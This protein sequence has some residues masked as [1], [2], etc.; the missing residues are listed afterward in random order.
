MT[1]RRQPRNYV[2]TLEERVASLEN[3]LRNNRSKDSEMS[4]G[5]Q[6]IH[7]TA[8]YQA[9]SWQEKDQ[10]S[11]SELSSSVGM[12]GLKVNGEEPRYLGSSSV[13]AFSRVIHSSLHLPSSRS[14]LEGFGG[15]EQDTS[16]DFSC[17]LPDDALAVRLSNA[18]FENIH[19]QYPFLHEPTFRQWEARLI[20][21]PETS[22]A[23]VFDSV[24]FFFVNM[25]S[26]RRVILNK[27]R[28]EKKSTV[29]T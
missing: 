12:L 3:Q 24:P 2:E 17:P 25:V 26:C 5:E 29:I 11:T 28:K 8:G 20:G 27:K 7:S 9:A 13:F 16:T 18:Y 1:R 10:D 21:P 15:S 4:S 14:Y 23:F 6:T 22:E 19:P